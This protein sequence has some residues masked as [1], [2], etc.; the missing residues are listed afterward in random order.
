MAETT[1]NIFLI[2]VS[3]PNEYLLSENDK[4]SFPGWFQI[5]SLHFYV[6]FFCIKTKISFWTF[7]KLLYQNKILEQLYTDFFECANHS[8][9]FV[10]F[11]WRK[12]EIGIFA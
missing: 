3:P 10:I 2:I 5:V 9:T 8:N 4:I 11:R 12:N 1:P 6:L 7:A